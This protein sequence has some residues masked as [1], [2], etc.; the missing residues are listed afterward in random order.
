[1]QPVQ[2][3]GMGGGLFE[4]NVVVQV[5]DAGGNVLALETTT[6]NAPDAGSGREGPWSVQMVIPVK[7]GTVG[8]IHAFSTTPADGSVTTSTSVAVTFGRSIEVNT[9]IEIS[10]PLGNSVLNESTFTVSGTGGGTFEGTVVVQALDAGGNVLAEQPTIID[11]PNAG[12][13]KAGPWSVQLSVSTNPGTI[14]KIN[15]YSP[16]PVDGSIMAA[17]SVNVTYGEGEAVKSFIKI[18]EPTKGEFRP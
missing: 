7:P 14:G 3:S 1:P 2:I 9:Y 4:G 15:A 10:E 18:T 8:Q 11:A 16:S 5:L 12:L 6:V 17:S 13:G